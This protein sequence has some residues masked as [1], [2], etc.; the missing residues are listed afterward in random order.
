MN[1]LQKKKFDLENE[2]AKIKREEEEFEFEKLK[3]SALKAGYYI[4]LATGRIE[5]DIWR[6]GE[7]DFEEI[8]DDY[9]TVDEILGEPDFRENEEVVQ[10]STPSYGLVWA[11]KQQD[12]DYY[13]I[14]ENEPC[15]DDSNY[16]Y[17]IAFIK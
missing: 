3:K 9:Y 6:K 12:N 13:L 8:G 11:K 14:D 16:V 15:L 4:P 5:N 7:R 1:E 10:I 2:L 17:Q